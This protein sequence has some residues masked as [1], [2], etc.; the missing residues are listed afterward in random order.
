MTTEAYE[1]PELTEETVARA[2][3]ERQNEIVVLD[4]TDGLWKLGLG[5]GFQKQWQQVTTSLHSSMSENNGKNRHTR[6]CNR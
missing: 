2:E 1:E 4:D 6:G 5:N 3:A